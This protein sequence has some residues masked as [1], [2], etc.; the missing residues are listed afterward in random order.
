M[1]ISIALVLLAL[2][3]GSDAFSV[4]VCV[5][6]AGATPKQKLR[7]ASGFGA[8]QFLMPIV[9]LLVGHMFGRVAGVYASYT[10]GGLLVVFGAAMVWRSLSHGITCPAMIHTSVIALI[11]ASLGVSLDALA[12]G[13]GYGSGIQGSHILFD[14]TFIGAV[15]FVMTIIGAELGGQIGKVLQQ[16]AP[17]VGGLILFGIGVR[18][19]IQTAT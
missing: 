9:G 4:A 2:A 12:V 1:E 3:L 16:R 13:F 19:I 15:A 7:L 11:T 10:G 17:V 5:G 18:I 14:S 8:F 6:L